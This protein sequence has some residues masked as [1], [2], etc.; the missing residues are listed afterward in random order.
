MSAIRHT[1][2]T[3]RSRG[4]QRSRNEQFHAPRRRSTRDVSSPQ[5]GGV[6]R[7]VFGVDRSLILSPKVA[8]PTSAAEMS[9]PAVCDAVVW[10]IDS[11]AYDFIIVNFAKRTWWGAR[12]IPAAR[13]ASRRQ[14]H[15][16][17]ANV[18]ALEYAHG[19]ALV[20]ADHGNAGRDAVSAPTID[21]GAQWTNPSGGARRRM[22]R[23]W[24]NA[25]SP[26]SWSAFSAVGTTVIECRTAPQPQT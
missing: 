9:A 25:N 12:G 8:R 16:V 21:D 7:A 18:E 2:V 24:A 14:D 4:D 15:C 22:T 23:R 20:A 10:P 1:D 26:V 6:K 13:K 17:R 19:V 3:W 5:R 11:G